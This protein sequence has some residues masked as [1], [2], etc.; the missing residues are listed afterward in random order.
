VYHFY[1]RDLEIKA[2][3]QDP[4]V[5]PKDGNYCHIPLVHGNETGKENDNACYG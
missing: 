3:R 5:F 2:R 4:S 1:N